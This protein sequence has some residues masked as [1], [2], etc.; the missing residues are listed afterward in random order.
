[1]RRSGQHV[2]QK[3]GTNSIALEQRVK[4]LEDEI[5][6][7]SPHL[8]IRAHCLNVANPLRTSSSPTS[9][10]IVA[11][12]RTRTPPDA[13]NG[14]ATTTITALREELNRE[15][16]SR[17]VQEALLRAERLRR[18]EVESM[19]NDTTRECKQP[20]VVPALLDAFIKIGQ[21]TG[22]ALKESHGGAIPMEL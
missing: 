7:A 12:M 3:E 11:Y 13:H 5:A 19:M 2:P 14:T 1:M 16:Q 4:A 9:H 17:R 20:F 6:G 10:G 21:M 22:D 15:Q 8:S 18:A